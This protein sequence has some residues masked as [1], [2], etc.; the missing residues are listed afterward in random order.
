MRTSLNIENNMTI[1]A[2]MKNDSIFQ[3]LEYD[4]LEGSKNI[5][6]AIQLNQIR[7]AGIRLKQGRILLRD[8]SIRVQAGALSFMKGDINIKNKTGGVLTLGKKIF[9]SKATGESISKPLYHGTGEIFLEPTFGHFALIFLED[10][11]IIIDDKMF[12]ACDEEIEVATH[13]IK[14]PSVAILGDEE[15]FSTKLKGSGIVLLEIPVPE[16][17]IFRCKIYKDTL[18]VDG[19]F[20]ILR[21]GN[22]E[23]TVEKSTKTIAGTIMSGEGLLNVYKGIGEVWL[24]PTKSIYDKLDNNRIEII[25]EEEDE[26]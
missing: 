6:V 10:E 18:K 13:V 11:E 15:L 25:D 12:Y 16:T 14:N 26:E 7:D 1:I 20:A 22:I 9:S 3:V 4:N 17:E 8:S 2:E 5:N 21:S 23:V 24:I 19:N